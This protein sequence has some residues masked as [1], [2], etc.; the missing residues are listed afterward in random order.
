MGQFGVDVD[1][2][3]KPGQISGGQ[4]QRIALCRAL[5]GEPAIVLA[6]EPTGNLD[7]ESASIVMQALSDRASDGAAVVIVTHSGA[8]T[9]AC[10]TEVRL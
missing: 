2:T 6:D 8:I 9:Q 5:I 3:R 7:P 10:D 1:P 4:A